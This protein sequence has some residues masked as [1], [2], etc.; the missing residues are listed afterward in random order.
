MSDNEI[1]DEILNLLYPQNDEKRIVYMRIKSRKH[2]VKFI[3][4][5]KLQYYNRKNIY[6]SVAE[7][8]P[9]F[10]H[11][12]KKPIIDINNIKRCSYI[13]VDLD[14]RRDIEW[15]HNKAVNV[16]NALKT[17]NVFD[18]V[19]CPHIIL[20]SGRGLHLFYLI[21]TVNFYKDKIKKNQQI[22]LYQDCAAYLKE[23]LYKKISEL[24]GAD[25]YALKNIDLD[26]NVG[27]NVLQIIRLPLSYN[28]SAKA[29]GTLIDINDFPRYYL[30]LWINELKPEKDINNN[31]YVRKANIEKLS[32]KRIAD[33]KTLIKI[34]IENNTLVGSRDKIMIQAAWT[35]INGDLSKDILYEI[36]SLIGGGFEKERYIESKWKSATRKLASKFKKLTNKKIM[37]WLDISEEESQFMSCLKPYTKK[38]IIAKQKREEKEKLISN[39]NK[40]YSESGNISETARKFNLSRNTVR[41]YINL[42]L[43]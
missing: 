28:S 7:R 37:E 22:S 29:R 21:D 35:I 11:K 40:Y 43:N 13:V 12:S 3:E 30:G 25:V 19:L 26:K 15:D 18:D 14:C 20:N 2:T 9:A 23:S 27:S 41:K 34:R 32:L 17:F 42:E 39:V 6:I 1:R 5:E 8:Y 10:D 31:N 4:I 36:G 33:Y 16:Y 38:E 24:K